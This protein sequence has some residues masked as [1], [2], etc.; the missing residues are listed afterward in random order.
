MVAINQ[1]FNVAAVVSFLGRSTDKVILG[2]LNFF[3]FVYIEKRLKSVITFN[4]TVV[5]KIILITKL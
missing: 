2:R 1:V 4:I 5:T 3:R